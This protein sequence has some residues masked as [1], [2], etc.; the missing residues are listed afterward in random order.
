[1]PSQP[2]RLLLDFLA[3]QGIELYLP[4]RTPSLAPA[5]IPSAV[6]G[7]GEEPSAPGASQH[8]PQEAQDALSQLRKEIG[9]C[10]RCP[11][12][13][14]RTHLV[15]GEGNP[16]ASLMFIGEGPGEEE[17]L[18]GRPFVGAAGELLNRMIA[19]M[20]YKREEVYIANVVKCRPPQNREPKPEEV[21]CCL[22]FLEQQITIVNPKVIVTL[23]KCAAQSL[24]RTRE[25]ISK[26]RG[27]WQRYGGILLM[28]T[29]HPAY[30][31]RNPGAK[32]EVWSDLKRVMEALKGSL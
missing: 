16:S 15:F 31:L 29:Y 20:G 26:L 12:A 18:Q 4:A 5:L 2:L 6:E 7:K 27:K 14:T 8:P 30:L 10:Q 19:A 17:D 22:P 32:R 28:P 13:K 9:D 1:M 21:A 23:G 3:E 25:P 24:L 11:L